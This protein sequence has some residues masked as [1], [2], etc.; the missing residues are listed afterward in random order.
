M[1]TTESER[2]NSMDALVLDNHSLHPAPTTLDL[3]SASLLLEPRPILE[4]NSV[5][6]PRQ[7]RRQQP[8][9]QQQQQILWNPTPI[10]PLESLEIV[11]NVS[12]LIL[13]TRAAQSEPE[14]HNDLIDLLRPFLAL[15]GGIPHLP[16]E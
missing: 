3:L 12:P 11:P 14:H 10:G 2:R 15:D 7:Q 9:Q 1:L 5:E 6:L 13:L 4:R 16:L 8:Q